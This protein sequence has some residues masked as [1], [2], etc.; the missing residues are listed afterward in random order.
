M[1]D[2]SILL[3]KRESSKFDLVGRAIEFFTGSPYTHTAIFLNGC[4][5]DATVWTPEG[6]WWPRSGIRKTVGTLSGYSTVMVPKVP[7]THDEMVAMTAVADEA[8]K[9]RIP[10]NIF[11][12]LVLA[13]VYPTRKF[14]TWIKWVPFQEIS[15]GEVC[16]EF[17]DD[18]YGS[19]GRDLF[20]D[21][22]DEATVPG[23]FLKCDQIEIIN[24]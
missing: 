6:K 9:N 3:F 19:C 21:R 18:E 22:S 1:V 16:S 2:G 15:Y 13:I 23:D 8:I 7:I 11:K 20:P 17:V 4:T 14:W 12:L 24:A 10:Y 5:Y